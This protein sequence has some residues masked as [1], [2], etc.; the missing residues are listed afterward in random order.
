[1]TAPKVKAGDQPGPQAEQSADREVPLADAIVGFAGLAVPTALAAVAKWVIPDQFIPDNVDIARRAS[2]SV[3]LIAI[4]LTWALQRRLTPRLTASSLVVGG[5]AF[6][7]MAQLHQRFAVEVVIGSS[8]AKRTYLTGSALT[9]SGRAAAVRCGSASNEDLVEC[10]GPHLIDELW[11]ASYHW[12]AGGFVFAYMVF[13]F[14]VVSAAATGVIRA[15]VHATSQNR[16][17]KQTGP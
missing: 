10:T 13:V 1:L 4:F 12:I 3:A 2:F 16:V 11:G 17:R 5:L 6:I 7:V 15:A 14:T 8:E 9:D